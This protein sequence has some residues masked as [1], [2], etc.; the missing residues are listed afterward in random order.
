MSERTEN[1][2]THEY[3]D[4]LKNRSFFRRFVRNIYLR[5]IKNL[6]IGKTID[7]GCGIGK[8]LKILPFG[9]I[10]FEVNKTAVDFCK[11]EG[12]P[13]ELYDPESDNYQFEMIE[14]GE[15]QTFTM[16]HVLE[17][18]ENSSLIIE[19]IFKG[20][21]RLGISRILFTVPGLKGYR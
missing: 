1:Q 12:I 15:F 17:H 11:T 16:N 6:C 21:N 20:C 2:Y 14:E 18:L 13:V 9:S 8:L 5:D 10:G 19:K 4:Y 7:F 3:F